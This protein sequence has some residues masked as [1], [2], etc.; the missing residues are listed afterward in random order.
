MTQ[1]PSVWD[2]V[3][4]LLTPWK[5]ERPQ[6]PPA[7]GGIDEPTPTEGPAASISAAGESATGT[8][9]SV[10]AGLP[11]PG[12]LPWVT[13]IALLMALM[14]QASL[15]PFPGAVRS[16][17]LGA[18]TYGLSAVW[19]VIGIWRGEWKPAPHRPD[20]SRVDPETVSGLPLLVGL[21][22][23]ALAFLLMGNN[24]F[25]ALNVSLWLVG[26]FAL[27]MALWLP[28][29]PFHWRSL[30]QAT[31]QT[32]RQR[33]WRFTWNLS[34]WGLVC[35]LA[36]G[37]IVFFRFHRLSEVP[38]EMTSDHAE[39][40]LDVWDILNGQPAI[41]FIRNTGREPLQFYLTAAMIKIF[42]TGYTLLSLKLGTTLLGFLLVFYMYALGKEVGNRRVGL[43]A[44]FMAGTSYWLNAI[45]RVALRF[46]LLPLFVAPVMFHLIRGMR[47]RSRN[48]M[49]LA[50]LFLGIGLHGYSPYRVVP[51]L[52]LVAVALYIVHA[53]SRGAR[54]QTLWGLISLI[55]I[56]FFVFLPLV[57]FMTDPSNP[58]RERFFF[59]AAT[60]LSGLEQPIPGDP[61]EILA[62]NLWKDLT[63]F[64]WDNG[65]VWSISIMNRP[66]LDIV[67]AALYF[68][69]GIML[70][71]R[72][73]QK[74]HWLDITLLLSIPVL[75][76]GAAL[77]I[78]F[79]NENPLMNRTSGALVPAFVI[80]ALML[81]NLMSAL[82]AWRP[83]AGGIVLAW[84]L[85]LVLLFFS[86]RQN[87]SLIF[88]QYQATY[89]AISLNTSE[90][91]Q[92][93]HS[94]AESIGS[95]DTA[96]VIPYPHW[97]DTRLVGMHAGQPTRDYALAP[98]SVGS[99]F[100]V[101]GYKLYILSPQDLATLKVLEDYYTQGSV[102]IY[103]SKLKKDFILFIAPPSQ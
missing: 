88:Q 77:A 19:L 34:R 49:L 41:F 5:G 72:Y 74:R 101:P 42:D 82:E 75:L 60:R 29:S 102:K 95:Y 85:A 54:T 69:G 99:T 43:F 35:L 14:A 1:E 25:T 15:E 3:R 40:L 67:G 87:Y 39:K 26:L 98:E 31:S 23:S 47:T 38:P 50:G 21:G 18:L 76:L 48:H 68:L 84:G 97:V 91:G 103:E 45:T 28:D 92:V 65:N 61:V 52:V 22:S 7:T 83:R 13:L 78:A 64:F 20:G 16:W 11:P 71:M 27:L 63:M 8:P 6:M 37:V 46:S 55:V 12:R 100:A 56:S 33:S 53:Q 4:S 10:R 94:F 9:E 30:W 24:R 79:P 36:F 58:D 86:T 93:I 81:D 96:W 59:R 32:L 62:S 57:R 51:L 90:M 89:T 66:A 17:K 80:A 70:L 73:L 2:F 44:M